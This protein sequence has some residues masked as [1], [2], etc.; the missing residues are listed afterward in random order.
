MTTLRPRRG[1][2][3][4]QPDQSDIWAAPGSA[5]VRHPDW[6]PP[7]AVGTV[8]ATG[9]PED[10]CIDIGGGKFKRI[11]AYPPVATGDRIQIAPVSSKDLGSELNIGGRLV[12]V[13][14]FEQL[15]NCVILES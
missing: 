14:S 2:V 7:E 6:I 10:R 3:F 4:F 15:G 13:L 1:H 5:L 8:I 11:T 12:R 9:D